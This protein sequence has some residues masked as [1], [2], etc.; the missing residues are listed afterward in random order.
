MEN[1]VDLVTDG[2]PVV[3]QLKYVVKLVASARVVV[4]YNRN[5]KIRCKDGEIFCILCST[6]GKC[7][8]AMHD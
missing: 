4:L 8:C 1:V 5:V 2:Q 6:S 3:V 7:H